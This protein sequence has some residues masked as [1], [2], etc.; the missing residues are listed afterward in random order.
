MKKIRIVSI[1]QGEAPKWVR[2]AW[3][4]IE[5]P[6]ASDQPRDSKPVGVISRKVYHRYGYWVNRNVAL[7]ILEEK[8]LKAFR[9]WL[10]YYTKREGKVLSPTKLF[11]FDLDCCEVV[12]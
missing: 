9:W 8:S 11:V 1:P 12:K 5:L 3:I 10:D 6:L 7:R 4:G 2:E